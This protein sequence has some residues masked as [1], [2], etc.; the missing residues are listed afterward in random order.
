[1]ACG[2]TAEDRHA[3]I[4]I[5]GRLIFY[6]SLAICLQ[7]HRSNLTVLGSVFALKLTFTHERDLIQRINTQMNV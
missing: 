4:G 5:F 6:Q 2:I 1:M 7:A 3:A